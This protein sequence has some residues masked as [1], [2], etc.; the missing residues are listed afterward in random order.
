MLDN[1]AQRARQAAEKIL[2]QRSRVILALVILIALIGIGIRLVSRATLSRETADSAL[3]VVVTMHPDTDA[4]SEDLVLP[5]NVQAYNQASI[6]ARV[7][8]YLKSWD[9]DIGTP[10]KQGQ[11]LGE[12]DAPEVDQQ[13]KQAQADLATA[14]ANYKLALSTNVRWQKL[15]ATDSVSKQD[16]D[17]KAGDAAAKKALVD[18]A[19]ANVAR[20]HDLESFK[21]VVAPF[22][23]IVTARN[24]DIGNLINA[25][26]GAELFRVADT[27]KLRIYV[28]VPQAYAATTRPGLKAALHFAEHPGTSYD[29]EIMRTANALDPATRT[30]Q[31]ELQMDNAAGELFPG[32]YAEVHFA[33]PGSAGRLKLPVTALMFRGQ[34]LQ[35]AVVEGNNH[36]ALRDIV[37][38]RDFGNVIE[39][40]SGISA[41]DAVVVDPPDSL[42]DGAEVRVVAP[43]AKEAPKD[44]SS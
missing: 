19:T 27:S 39:V 25:G 8:G 38:G 3:P 4:A 2:R 37:P 26:A 32:A 21:T 28:Q 40:L 17:E 42:T 16:A 30:L 5:G 15:L 44:K 22:D 24:T 23:G 7:S 12:I 20:L 34:G 13:L 43:H 31:V 10:V 6:F 36:V 1:S 18:S 35:V 9:T 14:E 41:T 11:R 29:A 33:I